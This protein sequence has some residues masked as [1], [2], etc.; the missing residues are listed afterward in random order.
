MMRITI[1]VKTEDGE[2]TLSDID[3]K[4]DFQC[5]SNAPIFNMHYNEL[6]EALD[7]IKEAIK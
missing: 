7:K 1:T 6:L 3:G 4:T 5:E 2:I